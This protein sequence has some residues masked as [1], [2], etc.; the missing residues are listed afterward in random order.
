MFVV[1]FEAII[2]NI[3]LVCNVRKVIYKSA[4]VQSHHIQSNLTLRALWDGTREP[5]GTS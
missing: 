1:D 4:L 5:A 2:R 3:F